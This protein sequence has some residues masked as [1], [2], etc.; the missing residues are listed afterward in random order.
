MENI[1]KENSPQKKEKEKKTQ[2]Q[3]LDLKITI[4]EMKISLDWIIAD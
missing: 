3:L 4:S 2:M 1:R